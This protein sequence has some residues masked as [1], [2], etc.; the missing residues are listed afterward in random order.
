MRGRDGKAKIEG[1]GGREKGEGRERVILT[2]KSVV[3]ESYV[4]HNS[5]SQI[6]S[7]ILI[8]EINE[9]KM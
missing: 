2:E 6:R 1:K 7:V 9:N 4:S 3:K 8:E 5:D